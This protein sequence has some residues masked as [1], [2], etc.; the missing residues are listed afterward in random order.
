V[1][2]KVRGLPFPLLMDDNQ[3]RIM[4]A[5]YWD[6]HSLRE[7][8]EKFDVSKSGVFGAFKRLNLPRRTLQ[9]A[10]HINNPCA[11]VAKRMNID[12]QAGM[13][14]P[15]I[16]S[17]HQYSISGVRHLLTSYGYKRSEREA[18]YYEIAS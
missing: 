11:D 9:H 17:K 7:T 1:M 13:S 18:R 12:Y 4:H 6:G 2:T 14:I 3:V 5:Y 15:K 10:M 16:A 8:A